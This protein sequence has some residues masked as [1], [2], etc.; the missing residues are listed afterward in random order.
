MRLK[1][2]RNQIPKVLVEGNP[3]KT[4]FG[5]HADAFGHVRRD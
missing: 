2:I 5:L 3:G 4:L 1:Q